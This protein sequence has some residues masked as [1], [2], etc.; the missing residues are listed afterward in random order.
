[1]GLSES[2]SKRWKRIAIWCVVILAAQTGASSDFA[3]N[4]LGWITG[5]TSDSGPR[6]HFVAQKLFHIVLFGGVG[7]LVPIPSTRAGWSRVILACLVLAV[8]SEM[9]QTLSPGR[10]PRKFDVCLNIVACAVPL[11]WRAR[12]SRIASSAFDA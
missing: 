11:Y 6:L 10:T 5:V 12:R 9:L 4:L 7:A 8:G 3:H 2:A 1:M